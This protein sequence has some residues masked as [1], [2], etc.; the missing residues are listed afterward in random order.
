MDVS[1]SPC[2]SIEVH[3]VKALQME[4][5]SSFLSSSITRLSSVSFLSSSMCWSCM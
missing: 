2:R 1:G 3:V 4:I 5:F